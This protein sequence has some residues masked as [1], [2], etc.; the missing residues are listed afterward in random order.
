MKQRIFMLIGSAVTS[1]SAYAEPMAETTGVSEHIQQDKEDSTPSRGVKIAG[2][3]VIFTVAMGTTAFI[4]VK[5]KL[6]KLKTT[7]KKQ[8]NIRH[9]FQHHQD[10]LFRQG[11]R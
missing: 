10:L 8:Q 1:I 3:L 2:F 4:V 9:I 11:N 6:K 7:K 5:P